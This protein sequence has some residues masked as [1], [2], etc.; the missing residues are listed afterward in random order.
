MR[1]K[2]RNNCYISGQT[3]ELERAG[4]DVDKTTTRSEAVQINYNTWESSRD[5]PP[6]RTSEADWRLSLL[7]SPHC[8][9]ISQVEL[10]RLTKE[11]SL[12]TTAV[13]NSTADIY[14]SCHWQGA[15]RGNTLALFSLFVRHW[16]EQDCQES[17]WCHTGVTLE[18]WRLDQGVEGREGPRTR[19]RGS[20]VS[21][22]GWFLLSVVLRLEL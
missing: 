17:H 5:V 18:P 3:G 7:H 15:G 14:L 6:L 1:T 10:S 4:Q 20:V 16:Y 8:V 22:P 19:Y 11:N 12:M 2:D 13:Y 21:A 9:C